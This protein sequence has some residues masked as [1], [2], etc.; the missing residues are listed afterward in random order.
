MFAR[1][2]AMAMVVLSTTMAPASR[3]A[4]AGPEAAADTSAAFARDL[5]MRSPA[6][7]GEAAEQPADPPV[8]PPAPLLVDGALRLAWLDPTEVAGLSGPVA[9]DEAARALR[10]LGISASWRRARAGEPSRAGEIRVILLDRAARTAGNGSVLG[11]TPTHFECEPFVWIH[12]P[13]VRG[14][15]GLTTGGRLSE[16]RDTHALGMALGRVIAHE[17]LHAL[18]PALP[19]GEGL[20][21]SRLTRGDLTLSVPPVTPGLIAHVRAALAGEREPARSD[22]GLLTA[23]HA[24]DEPGR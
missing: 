4:A 1:K 23:E 20:M 11:S 21:K 5:T 7:S 15:L 3:A 17:I 9:R 22:I 8:E 12:E 24:R 10:S 14:V 13:G 16:L 19:H 2:A 18:V 6:T